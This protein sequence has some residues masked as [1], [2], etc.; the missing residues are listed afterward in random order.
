MVEADKKAIIMKLKKAM[1]DF[2]AGKYT[3]RKTIL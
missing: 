1:R 2:K 3:A